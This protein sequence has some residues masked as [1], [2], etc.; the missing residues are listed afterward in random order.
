MLPRSFHRQYDVYFHLLSWYSRAA[1]SAQL[2]LP[3]CPR[4]VRDY[5][6]SCE[7]CTAV[8]CFRKKGRGYDV[9]YG[10]SVMPCVCMLMGCLKGPFFRQTRECFRTPVPSGCYTT[11][12][13]FTQTSRPN[14]NDEQIQSHTRFKRTL[15]SQENTKHVR[16]FGKRPFFKDTKRQLNG[17][18]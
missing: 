9:W 11:I 1:G 13:S 4:E 5:I 2:T 3:R 18:E 8:P 6:S 17:D 15:S 16:I 7:R 14:K 10:R 12:P